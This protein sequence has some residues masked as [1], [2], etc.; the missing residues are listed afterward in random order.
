MKVFAD[1]HLHSKYSRATSTQL[2]IP[3]LVKYARIKGLNLLGTGDFTHPLWLNELKENLKED[4]T[5]VLRDKDG[6]GF[7]LS[8]E[9]SSIYS[10]GGK[11]RRVHNVILAKSFE[12]VEQINEMLVRKKVNLEADGR[13]VCGIP[14][15]ELVELILEI[16]KG[17]EIIPA[18]AWT[19]WFSVFGSESGFDSIEECFKDQAKKIHALETGLSSDPA[20]NWRLSSL[21]RFA[22]VSNSDSHSYWPWR[23]GREANVF[24]LKEITYD[25]IVSA[26]REKDPKRFLYTIEVDPSYGK[27]HF[28]GHR[29]CNVCLNPKEALRFGNWCP[30]CKRQLTIGVLHRVEQ[31]ADRPEGYVPKGAIPFKSLIP[32]TEIIGGVLGIEQLYS[33]RIWEIYNKLI[34]RFGSEFFVLLE[35]EKSEMRKVV[36]E[37]IAKAIIDVR[38][39]KVEIRPGYDGVYGYPVFEGVE[40]VRKRVNGSKSKKPKGKNKS[41]KGGQKSLM[42]F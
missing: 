5:G 7:I 27:Y 24:E 12:I 6:F 9:I 13:P 8:G 30:V 3:N 17:C 38:E 39:G 15:P 34:E 14:C 1:L 28:D 21:D 31:L 41:E 4:G 42:E 40:R 35:A 20:M 16:D 22:L 2:N 26:I 18:H 10:Q 19:P 29:T 23:I 33:K 37:K 25:G 11:V 36:D 32:L